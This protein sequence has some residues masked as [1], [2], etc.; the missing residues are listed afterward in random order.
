MASQISL[1]QLGP[2]VD[3]AVKAALDRHHAKASN[4]FVINPGIIA[5]PL[6]DIATDVKVA[7][8]IAEEVTQQVQQA[9][10]LDAAAATK[11]LVSAVVLTPRAILCGFFPYPVPEIIVGK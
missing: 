3:K 6:L 7:Q 11:P 2:T 10:G 1:S 4:G 5:G 9:G 8:K